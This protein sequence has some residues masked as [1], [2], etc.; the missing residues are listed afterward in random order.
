MTREQHLLACI[1]EECSEVQKEIMKIF[2]FGMVKPGDTK[3][4]TLKG[5]EVPPNYESLR[6]EIIDL[7]GVINMFGEE[8]TD[9]FTEEAA[10]RIML[11]GQ[12][13]LAYM[14]YARELGQLE[15]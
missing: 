4:T 12:K 1:A 7:L 9:L 8:H 13:V 15:D 14:D 2:R 6:N 11:K 10:E 5:R 3:H